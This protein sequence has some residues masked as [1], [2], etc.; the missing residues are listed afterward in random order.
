VE[1]AD[2]VAAFDVMSAD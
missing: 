2:S 1:T